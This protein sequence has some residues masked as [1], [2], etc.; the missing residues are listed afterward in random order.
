MIYLD[1]D[2]F[3]S[4]FPFE[5][6]GENSSGF[7]DR[8]AFGDGVGARSSARSHSSPG[9]G[10][11]VGAHAPCHSSFY[12]ELQLLVQVE[13]DDGSALAR[14]LRGGRHV[15]RGGEDEGLSVGLGRR[16]AGLGRRIAASAPLASAAARVAH[17]GPN[18]SQTST[19]SRNAR[20]HLSSVKSRSATG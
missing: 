20:T 19:L 8:G 9:D 3:S 17:L 15:L 10:R 12:L 6:G 13:G 14:A 18:P 11:S 5:D 7:G 16:R 2:L 4:A 1:T